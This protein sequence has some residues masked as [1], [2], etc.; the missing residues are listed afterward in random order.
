LSSN[1]LLCWI[2]GECPADSAEH[3][4]KASDFRSIAPTLSQRSPA[5]LQI[6]HEATNQHIG[7]ATADAL[8]FAGSICRHCNNAGTQVYDEA[9]RRL[10][11]Y[12]HA[13]WRDIT[14]RGSFDLS[15]VFGAETAKQ[16]IRVQ[17]YFVRAFGC[18]LL[19]DG[20]RVDLESFSEALMAGTT[21]PEVTLLVTSSLVP[22]GQMLSYES[23]VSVLR[24]G[25]EVYSAVWMNLVHPVGIKICYLKAGAPV[26]EPPGFPWHPTRQRKLVKLSPY[27]G[28]TEPLVARRDL[29]I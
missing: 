29:R 26:R 3:K 2:C 9:W 6:N 1:N 7:S 5:F 14:A 19:E 13:N 12:L 17:L 10:S 16:A 20:I 23:D 24:N 8:K 27:K 21:H 11:S 22:A 25:D 18:K 28:D 15:K 4:V